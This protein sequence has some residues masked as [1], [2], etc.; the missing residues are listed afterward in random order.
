MDVL[1]LLN[2][3]CLSQIKPSKTA[4]QALPK[5]SIRATSVDKSACSIMMAVNHHNVWS[6]FGVHAFT[7]FFPHSSPTINTIENKPI[8]VPNSPRPRIE[9]ILRT[10]SYTLLM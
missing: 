4:Q 8:T 1:S 3:G 2:Q 7:A 5:Y 10:E 6:T 9:T